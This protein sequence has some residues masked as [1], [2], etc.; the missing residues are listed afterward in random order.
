M[1]KKGE[2][3]AKGSSEM[4][5]K[6]CFGQWGKESFFIQRQKKERET[7]GTSFST[8][9]YG[10]GFDGAHYGLLIASRN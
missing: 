5:A 8:K 6:R 7:N 10:S 1:E 9:L 4:V 2:K 3:P